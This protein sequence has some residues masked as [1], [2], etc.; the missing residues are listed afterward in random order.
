M[1]IEYEK[2]ILEYLNIPSIPKK[3]WDGVKPFKNA[4]GIVETR[5]GAK[6]YAVFE[7]SE[8]ANT[9]MVKKVFC[10]E[11]ITSIGEIYPVPDYMDVKNVETWDLDE[12][13]KVSANMLIEEAAELENAKTEQ[14]EKVANEWFFDE[15]HNI[16]E[17]RAWVASYRK[18]NKMRGAAI[19]EEDALKNFLYVIHKNQKRGLK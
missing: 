6:M 5:T 12:K 3:M 18:T 11:P 16:D 4:C 19:K 7:F 15:I 9:A 14:E 2:E 13:S 10:E 1:I 17:A 8:S